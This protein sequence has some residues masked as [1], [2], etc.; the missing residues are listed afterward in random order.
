MIWYELGV[1][2]AKKAGEFEVPD[3]LARDFL[4][5]VLGQRLVVVSCP[6]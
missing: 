5:G 2:G 4:R 6:C 1:S 3:F